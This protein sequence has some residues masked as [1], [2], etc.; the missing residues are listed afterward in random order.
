MHTR[1]KE[2]QRLRPD[3]NHMHERDGVTAAAIDATTAQS[4]TTSAI[5]EALAP[6]EVEVAAG[7]GAND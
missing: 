4:G 5:D 2:R 3:K 6:A 7:T 1:A